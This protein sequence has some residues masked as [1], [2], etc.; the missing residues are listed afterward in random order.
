MLRPPERKSC[1]PFCSGTGASWCGLG[2]DDVE[3]SEACD[4]VYEEFGRRYGDGEGCIGL[5]GGCCE[6]GGMLGLPGAE[7]TGVCGV[8]G[9]CGLLWWLWLYSEGYG[10]LLPVMGGRVGRCD[11]EPL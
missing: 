7:L 3:S 11:W 8:M 5:R 9:V 10:E 1:S 2:C 4:E 6:M